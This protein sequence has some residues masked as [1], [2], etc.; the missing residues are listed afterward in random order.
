MN[1]PAEPSFVLIY[2]AAGPTESV[3]RRYGNIFT[4]GAAALKNGTHLHE[5]EHEDGEGG[6]IYLYL[7]CNSPTC[8][9]PG[10]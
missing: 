8:A 6:V 5:E 10:R 7:E 4:A 2:Q 9:E 3:L 1:G